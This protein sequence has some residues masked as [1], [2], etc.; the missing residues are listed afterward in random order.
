MKTSW[1]HKIRAF[2]LSCAAVLTAIFVATSLTW[3]PQLV[4]PLAWGA[5]TGGGGSGVA[6]VCGVVYGQATQGTTPTHPQVLFAVTNS[7]SMDGNTSGANFVGSGQVANGNYGWAGSWAY[8]S[9]NHNPPPAT[10]PNNYTVPSGF[11]PPLTPASSPLAPYS[12]APSSPPLTA[13]SAAELSSNGYVMDNGPT[14]LNMAKAAISMA[15]QNYAG[16]IDF[17]LANYYSCNEGEENTW[18]YY[19][20]PSSLD[21]PDG[22]SGFYFTNTPISKKSGINPATGDTYPYTVANPCYQQSGN[23]DCNNLKNFYASKNSANPW[24]NIEAYQYV[25]IRHSSDEPS[26]ND[27]L[28]VNSSYGYMPSVFA[29]TNPKTSSYTLSQYNQNASSGLV[30]TEYQNY[31]VSNLYKW[32]GFSSSENLCS[33]GTNGKNCF[34]VYPTNSGFIPTSQEVL[35]SARGRGFLYNS[36]NDTGLPQSGA[37]AVAMQTAGAN[38]TPASIQSVI[39]TFAPVLQSETSASSTYEMKSVASQSA[40][41]S[42]FQTA[43]QYLASMATGTSNNSSCNEQSI[44]LVTD[45]LPTEDLN[46]NVWPPLGSAMANYYGITASYNADGSLASTNDQALQDTITAIS[47]LAAAGVHTYVVGVGAGVNPG[48]NPAAAQALLAM[49]VA[50]GTN[51]YYPAGDQLQLND[52]IGRIVNTI[53]LTSVASSA[54]VAPSTVQGNSLIY[55]LLADSAPTAGHVQAFAVNAQGVPSTTPSWD[56]ATLMNANNRASAL[57]SSSTSGQA[58]LLTS[59]DAAAFQIQNPPADPCAASPSEIAGYTINPSTTAYNNG[60]GQTCN[61]LGNRKPGWFLG[62]IS[63]ANNAVLLNPPGNPVDLSLPGYVAW[64]T[65]AHSRPQALLYTSAD[66]FLYS[67]NAQTGAFNWGWMPRASVADLQ[68]YAVLPTLGLM[69]GRFAAVDAYNGATGQWATYLIGNGQNGGSLYN[70]QLTNAGLPQQEI[71]MPQPPSGSTVPVAGAPAVFNIPGTALNPNGYTGVSQI[72]VEVTNSG[73]TASPVN[74]LIEFNVATGASSVATIPSGAVNGFVTSRAYVDAQSGVLY[75]GDSAGHVYTT[76]FSGNAATDASNLTLLGTTEDGLPVHYIG[77]GQVSGESYVWVATTSGLTVFGV[78]SN[79]FGPLWA[80]TPSSGYT[81][82]GTTW[83]A[84]TAIAPLQVGSVISDAPALVNNILVVP[85]YVPQDQSNVCGN[86][87]GSG[88]YDFYTLSTGS[89]PKNQITDVNGNFIT[90][91]VSAG[92][93]APFTPSVSLSSSGV[94]VFG[95]STGTT[96]PSD[97]WLFKKTGMNTVTQWRAH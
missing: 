77:I 70:L 19:T 72:G 92:S 80:T 86:A 55:D 40:I 11:T 14:R 39:N 43:K 31:S 25:L 74:T 75:L 47:N 94:P 44:V 76:S 57:Y 89:F 36:Y 81:Y 37:I 83:T 84:T 15:L 1:N 28:M 26:I 85:D 56:A 88:Y 29:L 58:T 17:A 53:A 96:T 49:A 9:G 20:S 13:A 69:S 27:V 78:G 50:G 2:F 12:M 93:G 68:N 32:A 8:S 52:T 6:G 18:V 65:A 33:T 10:S 41:A 22:R 34:P 4:L 54:P 42:I 87:P 21:S 35:F 46:G 16:K 67:S 97:P 61:Y 64:A 95:G 30:S 91:T 60:S 63:N 59:M 38:P 90:G 66:G 62:S 73:T 71:P 45:G 24:T 3:A 48:V 79:G 5:S 7:Q 51:Q 23:T 82:S